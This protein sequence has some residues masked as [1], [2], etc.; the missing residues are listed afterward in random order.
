MGSGR[1]RRRVR[2]GL[3]GRPILLFCERKQRHLGGLLQAAVQRPVSVPRHNGHHSDSHRR[4][5]LRQ[6][7]QSHD[8]AWCGRQ[9][10]RRWAVFVGLRS[11]RDRYGL[12]VVVLVD[13][14]DPGHRT[15]G[16]TRRC[17]GSGPPRRCG[18]LVFPQTQVTLQKAAASIPRCAGGSLREEA[19]RAWHA[20]SI[21]ESRRAARLSI[22]PAR[23][24]GI[25]YDSRGTGDGVEG[26]GSE[27]TTT[28]DLESSPAKVGGRKAVG[29]R[30]RTDSALKSKRY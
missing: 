26:D 25:S 4:L 22:W 27:R 3:P 2:S 7:G 21:F 23:S 5:G 20:L 12:V 11:Q 16:R 18:L 14:P 15:R 10:I 9:R 17:F 1:I 30:T 28:C 19:V 8:R 29:Y 13:N 6:R 24:R